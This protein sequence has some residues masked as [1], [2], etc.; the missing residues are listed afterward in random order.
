MGIAD[1]PSKVTTFAQ[2]TDKQDNKDNKIPRSLKTKSVAYINIDEEEDRDRDAINEFM[3][4]YQ[5]LWRN[6]FAKYQN[7]GYKAKAVQMNT[8]DQAQSQ[9]PALNF[10]E[11]VKLV[12]DHGAYP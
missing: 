8:Y 4:K 2:G 5:K 10:A 12:K 6:I 1:K 11:I 9:I 7:Q 3:R